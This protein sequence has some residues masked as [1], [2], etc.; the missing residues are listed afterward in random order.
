MGN[1]TRS[2]PEVQRREAAADAAHR[3]D[4]HL[5]TELTEALLQALK[6]GPDAA[7]AVQRAAG[8]DLAR[9]KLLHPTIRFVSSQGEP[10]D[11]IIEVPVDRVVEV[12]TDPHELA[13]L[14]LLR[15][16]RTRLWEDTRIDQA[17]RVQ[18]IALCGDISKRLG[19]VAA[20]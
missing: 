10:A 15:I 8:H 4:Q 14:E 1:N 7:Y 5:R 9:L 3:R 20:R 19:S 12:L 18:L 6:V 2:D 16:V 17:E 11:R 13:S